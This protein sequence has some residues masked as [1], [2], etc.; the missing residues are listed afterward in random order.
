M[1][2]T[3]L[4]APADYW[5]LSDAARAEICDGCGPNF[6]AEFIP[7]KL[8]GLDI[9]DACD[10]HDYMYAVGRSEED[11][12]IADR[13]FLNNMLRIINHDSKEVLKPARRVMALTYYYIVRSFGAPWFWRGKNLPEEMNAPADIF[14]PEFDN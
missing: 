1:T 9:S 5:C 12:H 6:L 4:Y 10:I 14:G 11:R 7:D 13:V 2:S 8:L 3:L